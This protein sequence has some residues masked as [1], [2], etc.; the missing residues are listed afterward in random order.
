[1]KSKPTRDEFDQELD[2]V[3]RERL[4]QN[5]GRV[6]DFPLLLAMACSVLATG[7]LLGVLAWGYLP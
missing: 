4:A 6:Y 3:I 7:F 2:R 1:M 5:Y